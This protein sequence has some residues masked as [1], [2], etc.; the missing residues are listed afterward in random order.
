VNFRGTER[1]EAQVRRGARR[2]ALGIA[3]AGG[4]VAMGLTAQAGGPP[5]WVPATVGAAGGGLTLVLLI[6]LLRGN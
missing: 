2:L 5:A 4:L 6:D 1:L 3:A